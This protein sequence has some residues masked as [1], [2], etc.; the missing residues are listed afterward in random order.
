MSQIHFSDTETSRLQNHRIFEVGRDLWRSSCPTPL[1]NQGRLEPVLVHVQMA[2]DC[3]WGQRLH[4]LPGQPVLGLGHCHSA[5][6]FPDV[7]R[8][9]S[10]LQ[11]VS[12]ASGCVTGHHWKEPGSV[13]F[14]VSSYQ[15]YIDKILL[16]LFSSRLNS[17]SCL[18]L[19]S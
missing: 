19:S 11:F 17:C 15:S 18:S 6:V 1:L 13:L 12:S 5:K 10:V 2:F 3:L 7:Q 9:H 4:S 8:E 16:N 14:V